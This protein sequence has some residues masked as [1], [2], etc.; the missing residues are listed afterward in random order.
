MADPIQLPE[1]LKQIVDANMGYYRALGR[2][3]ADYVK[4]LGQVWT[5]AAAGVIP[6]LMG[7]MGS[8]G[9]MGSMGSMG[10]TG[11]A[12]AT[13][14]NARATAAPASRSAPAATASPVPPALVLEAEAGQTA[15]AVFMVNN[16]L[17]RAVS[18]AVEAS[19][20]TG[21]DGRPVRPALRVQPGT[22]ALEPGGR[23]LVQISVFVDEQL[24]PG[25][26]YR[27]EVTVPGLSDTPMPVLLRRKATTMESAATTSSEAAPASSRPKRGGTGK[28]RHGGGGG[29]RPTPKRRKGS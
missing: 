18:A 5:D 7:S 17:A 14:A 26:G 16:A 11:A 22:V 6:G 2:V 10:S 23:Q 19:D 12:G 20:F 3:T 28:P 4:A 1:P 9:S 21:P 15:Q 24:E 8:T 27:G 25:V 13:G 29:G